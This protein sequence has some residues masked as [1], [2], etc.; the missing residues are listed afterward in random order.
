M[1]TIPV[2]ENINEISLI[3]AVKIHKNNPSQRSFRCVE[4]NISFLNLENEKYIGISIIKIKD[5][6]QNKCIFTSFLHYLSENFDE[7]WIFQSNLKMSCILLT[8]KM[9]GMYFTNR[10]TGEHYWI[11]NPS[12]NNK[13]QY[14]HE[15][16]EIIA[17]QLAKLKSLMSNYELFEKEYVDNHDLYDK[18]VM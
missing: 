9:N 2:F 1:S 15:K 17:N 4:G 10:Y 11:K 7:I 18:Y 12:E 16:S 14:N 3:D 8:I 13:N 5:E 6:L